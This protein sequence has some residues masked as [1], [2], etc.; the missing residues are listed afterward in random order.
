MP[1]ITDDL[2]FGNGEDLDKPGV[3]LPTSPARWRY[4]SRGKRRTVRFDYWLH[5]PGV[6]D[7]H[8]RKKVAV[9]RLRKVRFDESGLFLAEADFERLRGR[10]MEAALSH[11]YDHGS[12]A[13]KRTVEVID[14]LP[15]STER[16]VQVQRSEPAESLP[17]FSDRL[18]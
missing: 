6:A 13:A 17:N 2:R 3:A 5:T 1:T 14:L 15:C 12:D 7:R 10:L 18:A 9:L 16:H 8:D 11:A 4:T